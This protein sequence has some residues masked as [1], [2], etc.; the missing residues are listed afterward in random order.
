[1]RPSIIAPSTAQPS[2]AATTRMP[3]IVRHTG[4]A[5][6]RRVATCPASVKP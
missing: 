4:E 5:V 3:F 1:M 6:V 2:P